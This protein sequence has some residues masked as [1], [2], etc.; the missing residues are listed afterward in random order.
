MSFPRVAYLLQHLL[1]SSSRRQPEAAAVVDG[2]RFLTYGDLEAR[3]NQVAHL[4]A[5]LGVGPGHRVGLFLDK[6]IEA[7]VGLF[8]VLKA[9]GAYV[10]LDPAAPPARLG[11]IARDCGLRWLLTGWEK[12]STWAPIV[13]SGAPTECFVVLNEPDD[14]LPGAV[15]LPDGA[16]LVEPSAID[17]QPTSPRPTTTI[18]QDLAY[19]LYTSGSTGRP[20]GVMLSHLNALTFVNWAVQRFD[21]TSDDR[22]SSH[23]PLHFDL[24]VF[25]VFAAAA[26]G[27]AVVL[28]PAR[29]STFPREVARFIEDYAITVWY[30]VPSVLSMLSLRGGLRDGSL[31]S[32]RAVLFAG[33]VFPTQYLRRLMGQ[34]P[35]ARFHNLYGPTETNVCTHYEVRE[36]ADDNQPIPIGRAIANVDVYAATEDGRAAEPGEVGEL[37]V[38]GS[39]VMSGYWGDEERSRQVLVSAPPATGV[40]GPPPYRT[41]D[42]VR[43]G[44]DGDFRFLGRRDTQLKCRGYRIEPGDVEAAVHAHPTVVECAVVGVPDPLVGNRLWAFLSVREGVEVA[45]L[46]KFTAEQLPGYMVPEVFEVCDSLPRTS[47][48]KIDR[49]ALRRRAQ[50]ERHED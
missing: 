35:H 2:P 10:P 45:E 3:S 19:V 12:A 50:E 39:T 46:R 47:T 28:V 11:Y 26:A 17:A 22:L 9:G 25:D 38:R 1:E 32:V 18:D 41:G 34:L 15:A 16:R 20:K 8:G 36:L 43:L 14:G 23:A 48:G 7:V 31:P 5:A 29:T 27:A 37:C 42:L 13:G 6:S 4:L 44:D 24:S 33:E 40:A 49:Q 30:S 21:L